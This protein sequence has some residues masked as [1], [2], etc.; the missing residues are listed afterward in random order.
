VKPQNSALGL[1]SDLYLHSLKH[2]DFKQISNTMPITHVVVLEK[3]YEAFQPSKMW[4]EKNQPLP[5]KAFIN[6]IRQMHMELDDS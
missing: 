5:T 1:L 3:F 6:L 4:S 2:H